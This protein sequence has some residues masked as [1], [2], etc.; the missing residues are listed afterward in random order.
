MQVK[1]VQVLPARFACTL[2]K[3]TCIFFTTARVRY[4]END[5]DLFN[6]SFYKFFFSFVIV[7]VV[8]LAI[9]LVVGSMK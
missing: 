3:F 5:M 4:T 8:T 9:I 7:V 1:N 2:K 6:A